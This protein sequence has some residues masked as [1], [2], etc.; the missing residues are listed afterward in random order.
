LQRKG[1]S[2]FFLLPRSLNFGFALVLVAQQ[3]NQIHLEITVPRRRQCCGWRSSS[4]LGTS[5]AQSNRIIDQLTHFFC[6]LFF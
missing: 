1:L 3:N 6:L 5:L 2:F 4:S